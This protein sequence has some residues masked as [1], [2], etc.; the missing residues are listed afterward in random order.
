MVIGWT[1]GTEEFRGTGLSHKLIHQVH[2]RYQEQYGSVLCK[3]VSEKAN[4]NCPEVV[5][6]AARWAAEALLT[7]FTNY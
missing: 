3:H 4:G 1:C 7:Q 2:A 6:R 5:G